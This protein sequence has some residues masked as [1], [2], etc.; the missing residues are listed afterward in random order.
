MAEFVCTNDDCDK[1]GQRHSYSKVKWTFDN[2]SKSLKHDVKC[3][4]CGEM[5]EYIDD[6]K[7]GDINVYFASFNAKSTEQ[8]KEIL[9]KRAHL[10][11]KTKMKDRIPEVRKRILGQS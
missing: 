8:K 1:K 5:M 2:V 3:S 9:K 4:S 11:N 6:K 7:E 10:H